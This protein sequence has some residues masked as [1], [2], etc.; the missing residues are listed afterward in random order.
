VEGWF[1]CRVRKSVAKG[2]GPLVK[3]ARDLRLLREKVG[4][5]T[6]RVLSARAHYSEAALSQAAAAR[7][8]PSLE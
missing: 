1:W 4:K 5:P 6:Y 8:L 2:V 3:F 7:K